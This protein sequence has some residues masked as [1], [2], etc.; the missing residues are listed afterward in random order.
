[1][2][3]E[4]ADALV[5]RVIDFSETSNIV[6]LLTREFGKIHAL[7][8][9]GRRPKGPFESALDLLSECR[10]VF[11]RK[12]SGAL[13]LLTEAKLEKRFRGRRGDLSSLYAGYY[14][15]ELLSELTHDLDPHPELYDAAVRTLAALTGTGPIARVVL[16]FELIALHRAGHAPSLAQC[17]GCGTDIEPIGR[18]YFAHAMG[19]VLCGACRAGR[20]NVVSVSAGA[21]RVLA[22]YADMESEDWQNV[23]L[24]TRGGG[25]IRALVNHY[26][27]HVIGRRPRMHAYLGFLA[28]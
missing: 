14:V 9:G 7:A 6:T 5:L 22:K 1:M 11:L 28:G 3:T 27:C 16:R 19:G 15:A 2:S 4:K 25:E 13:D 8:K 24:P 20:K 18:V 23:E 21:I 12:S 10:V 26:L 17:V